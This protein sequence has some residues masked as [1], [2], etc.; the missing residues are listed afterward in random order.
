[1]NTLV[2]TT[3]FTGHTNTIFAICYDDIRDQVIS[4]GKDGFVIVWSRDGKV[5]FLDNFTLY[6]TCKL[7]KRE[8]GYSKTLCMLHG[9]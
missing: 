2:A 6:L 8:N 4:S 7:A 3:S 9:H 1:M 5:L